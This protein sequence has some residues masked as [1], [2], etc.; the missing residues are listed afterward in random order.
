[1]PNQVYGQVSRFSPNKMDTYID[2]DSLIRAKMKTVDCE[3]TE[4]NT[5]INENWISVERKGD[6]F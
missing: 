4:L 6:R 5:E 3:I 2:K 1:M